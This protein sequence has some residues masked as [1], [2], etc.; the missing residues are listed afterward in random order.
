M[1]VTLKEIAADLGVS[2]VTVSKV[3]RNH[4]D[5]SKK[6]RDLVLDR[7]KQMGYRP[8]LT[9]RSLV[10]GRTS[11]VGLLV[12]DLIHPFFAEVARALAATLRK[13]GLY[14]LICSSEGDQELERNQV[15]HLLSRRL[16]AVVIA[17]LG[18]DER[19]LQDMVRSQTPLVL[20]DRK[21]TV[22]G[23]HFVGSNDLLVGSHAT[24]HLIAMGCRRIAYRS[25]ERAHRRTSGPDHRGTGDARQVRPSTRSGYT[26][27]RERPDKACELQAGRDEARQLRP[28]SSIL[29]AE[30][31][32]AAAPNPKHNPP[33]R[34]AGPSMDQ[35]PLWVPCR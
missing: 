3:L 27:V 9:A 5:I 23:S 29:T 11:L 4:E 22:S 10:T 30:E 15:E 17:S 14:L 25:E 35:L 32:Q 34:P 8:N 20:I 6:T 24:E 16:D 1:A 18:D 33:S 21:V 31:A 2:V 7:A 26:D 19:V 28:E 13:Q 12:H